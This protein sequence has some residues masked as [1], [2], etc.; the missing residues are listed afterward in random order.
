MSSEQNF[1]ACRQRCPRVL[2]LLKEVR[3]LEVQK[4]VVEAVAVSDFVVDAA[5]SIARATGED[6]DDITKTLRQGAAQSLDAR[7]HELWVANDKIDELTTTCSGVLKMCASRGEQT[8]TAT[9]CTSMALEAGVE[10][11]NIASVRRTDTRL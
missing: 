2:G 9:T 3:V 5:Y 10:H 1:E 11:R 6:A 8:F 4:E 7:D